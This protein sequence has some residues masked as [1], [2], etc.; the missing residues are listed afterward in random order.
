L[1]YKTYD[2]CPICSS[3][4]CLW[5]VKHTGDEKFRIDR[6]Q[7]CGYAFV[8]PRP[9]MADSIDHYSLSKHGSPKDNKSI[10]M[11]LEEEQRYPNS[12][13]DAKRI[14]R[15]IEPMRPQSGPKTFLDIGCGYGFF[16]REAK[17]AGYDVT[18]LE[19]SSHERQVAAELA[20]IEPKAMS[21]EHFSSKPKYFSVILMSQILEHVNDV[22]LFISK[23]NDL[24]ID[25]G[26]LIVALPNF[27]SI[28]RKILQENDPYICPPNHLNFFDCRNL[29]TLLKKHHFTVEIKQHVSRIPAQSFEKRLSSLGKPGISAIHR[30]SPIL[31]RL[32]DILHRGMMVN[33]YA[34]K[35][36]A[37]H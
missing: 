11:V 20:G 2:S 29:T 10:Q 12:I 31:L 36:I 13:I 27:Q 15:T 37:Q 26:V 23:A 16:S 22:N 28:F 32:F 3:L 25:G 21:F 14:I 24:L 7:Q 6:C 17:R 1:E 33:I 34:K 4:I 5:K 18:A 35:Q 8:N 19:L 30:T 9:S